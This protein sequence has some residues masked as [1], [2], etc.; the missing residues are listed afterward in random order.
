MESGISSALWR[1]ALERPNLNP[2]DGA[3]ALLGILCE[4]CQDERAFNKLR[5]AMGYLL[6]QKRQEEDSQ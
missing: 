3:I 4:E 1:I 6:Y 2:I 5:R